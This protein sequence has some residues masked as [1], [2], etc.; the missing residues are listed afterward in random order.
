ML[1]ELI[2]VRMI[3]II[4]VCLVLIDEIGTAI[5]AEGRRRIPR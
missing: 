5:M 4:V 1:M 3:S 2:G